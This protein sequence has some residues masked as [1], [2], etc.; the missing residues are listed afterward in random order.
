[1]SPEM[2]L[3]Q[4]PIHAWMG[5]TRPLPLTKISEQE[6]ILVSRLFREQIELFLGYWGDYPAL[7]ICRTFWRRARYDAHATFR[8]NRF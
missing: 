4:K 2:Q 3:M 8:S 6:R 1:M 5:G 7:D